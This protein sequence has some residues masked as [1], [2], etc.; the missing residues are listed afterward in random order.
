[1]DTRSLERVDEEFNEAGRSIKGMENH[2][3]GLGVQE[4]NLIILKCH[5]VIEPFFEV[6][7]ALLRLDENKQKRLLELEELYVTGKISEAD[8]WELKLGYVRP[9]Y[10]KFFKKAPSV[11]N[12]PKAGKRRFLEL[13]KMY[14]EKTI[15]SAE[16]EELQKLLM[17]YASRQAVLNKAGSAIRNLIAELLNFLKYFPCRR[18]LKI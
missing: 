5:P 12:L 4:L 13:Q 18:Q 10:E 3:S 14:A 17:L 6:D 8:F 2:A 9:F 1:M 16:S 11:L 15:G 7:D